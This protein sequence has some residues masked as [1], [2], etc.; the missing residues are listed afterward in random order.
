V[1][2]IWRCVC[3]GDACLM[4]FFKAISPGD[5]VLVSQHCN[6]FL[7]YFVFQP[8][9]YQ[10]QYFKNEN[11]TLHAF[12]D[13]PEGTTLFAVPMTQELQ[14]IHSSRLSTEI[15]DRIDDSTVF[16][17]KLFE[18]FFCCCRF[19]IFLIEKLSCVCVC[20]CVCLCVCICV[21]LC[22]CVCVCVC[23]YMCCV[24]LCVFVCICV[25]LCVCVCVCVCVC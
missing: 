3:G 8:K 7:F 12:Y 18:V 20:V 15:R 4:I 2:W 1:M 14:S 21:C 6:F 25:Y 17:R 16:D 23:V 10:V 22:V 11:I 9:L 19:C 24:C 5:W 13:F